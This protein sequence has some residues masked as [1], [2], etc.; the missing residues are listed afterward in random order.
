M[1]NYF[2][3]SVLCSFVLGTL[4]LIDTATEDEVLME[5]ANRMIKMSPGTIKT[6]LNMLPDKINRP[7]LKKE[8]ENKLN[9]D[10]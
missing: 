8:I 4:L 7:H 9:E 10:S 3:D 2:F 1:K 6:V 5:I